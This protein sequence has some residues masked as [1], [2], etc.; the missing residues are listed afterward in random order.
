M[1]NA[2]RAQA[3][4]PKSI[5]PSYLLFNNP[6]PD[7]INLSDRKCHHCSR[8]K[9]SIHCA[10]CEHKL[11]NSCTEACVACEQVFCGA[12]STI[13]YSTSFERVFCLTCKNR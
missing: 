2:R 11:C 13:D 9:A 3:E 7:S 8:E 5:E 6:D 12:C 4:T 10:F 1:G